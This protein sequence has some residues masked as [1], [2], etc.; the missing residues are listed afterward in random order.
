MSNKR[1]DLTRLG[2]RARLDQTRLNA[3]S[4]RSNATTLDASEGTSVRRLSVVALVLAGIYVIVQGLGFMLNSLW[5]LTTMADQP[6]PFDWIGL[7]F[8][9]LA[10]ILFGAL[11]WL[12]IGKRYQLAEWL[13][14]ESELEAVVD[15]VT[16]LRAGLILFGVILLAEGVFGIITSISIWAQVRAAD[17]AVGM[18]ESV[19]Y[20]F[21]QVLSNSSSGIAGI[22]KLIIGGVLV[23]RSEAVTSRL[24]RPRTAKSAQPAAVLECPVCHYPYDPVDYRDPAMAKCTECGSPLDL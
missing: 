6:G 9:A 1:F 2:V 4:C 3:S 19:P 11:G 12:L 16:M 5:Y 21:Y 7:A 15:P 8:A 18:G 20:N 24:W 23:K 14:G 17:I 22:I 13:F 10:V